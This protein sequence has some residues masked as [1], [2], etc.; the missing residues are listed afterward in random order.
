M[1]W[2]GLAA[3]GLLATQGHS[4]KVKQSGGHMVCLDAGDD[5]DVQDKGAFSSRWRGGVGRGD[6]RKR[7]ETRYANPTTKAVPPRQA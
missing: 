6:S 5:N 4:G 3:A 2:L 1:A 7:V